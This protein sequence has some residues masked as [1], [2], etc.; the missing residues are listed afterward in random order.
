MLSTLGDGFIQMGTTPEQRENYL[1]TVATAWNIACLDQGL[2][3]NCI[4]ETVYKFEQANPGKEIN[5]E[6][7]EEDLRKLIDRKLTLFPLTKVQIIEV[8]ILQEAGQEKVMAVSLR[9]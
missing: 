3:E 4:R 5:S 1:R 7:Y 6:F 8:C 9:M 2:R